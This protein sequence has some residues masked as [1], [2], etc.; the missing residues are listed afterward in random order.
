MDSPVW[1]RWERMCL[2]LQLS[3]AD[4]QERQLKPRG[5]SKGGEL[6]WLGTGRRERAGTRL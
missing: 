1:P 3:D 2:V 5:G 6:A 4:V